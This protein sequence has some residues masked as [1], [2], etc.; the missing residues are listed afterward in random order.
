MK[1]V[2]M[3][4]LVLLVSVSV[5]SASEGYLWNADANSDK[6]Y[7]LDID[8][9]IISSFDSPG[10]YPW[11][12]AYDGEYLWNVDQTTKKVYKLNL[13]GEIMDS[14]GSPTNKPVDLTY[15]G[16]YLWHADLK[17]NKIYKTD[18]EGT[19][20]GFIYTNPRNMA[21]GLTHDG[22]YLYIGDI[23]LSPGWAHKLDY[24]GNLIDSYNVGLS[25][26]GLA[27]DKITNTLWISN[28]EKIRNIDINGNIISEFNSPSGGS[29]GITLPQH[30]DS[31]DDGNFNFFDNC[32]NTPNPSQTDSDEDNVGNICDNCPFNFNPGQEDSD[33]DGVGNACDFGD[34]DD[35][36]ER[37]EQLE[38]EVESLNNQNEEI[39]E[40]V[41]ELEEK[42]ENIDDI[43]EQV[44]LFE[45][46]INK[47]KE[48]LKYLPK[49]TR[50][51]MVCGVLEDSDETQ[52]E[53]L[54]LSCELETKK[55]KIKCKCDII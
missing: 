16:E 11:G 21:T 15:D 3:L 38:Q 1:K 18:K 32:P 20:L 37:I 42:T 24:D 30:G 10:D 2:I 9:E 34:I 35:L 26:Y 17:G 41:E 12:L 40:K 53:D 6:I 44:S 27:W 29:T 5:V 55:N 4:L 13:D 7:L 23:W 36:T 43:E 52:I 25:N 33:E 47:I 22:T 39:Q 48:Y 49:G 19:V 8:G 14:F 50:K 31:D 46:I 28:P 51:K 45:A 54:G